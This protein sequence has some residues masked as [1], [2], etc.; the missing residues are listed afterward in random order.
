MEEE[1]ARPLGECLR[2][3]W[4]VESGRSRLR[5]TCLHHLRLCTCGE[6]PTTFL[7]H[8]SVS[9]QLQQSS[10]A[11]FRG[12]VGEVSF[13]TEDAVSLVTTAV[14]SAL[15]SLREAQTKFLLYSPF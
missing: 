9:S 7:T 10:D 4:V 13:L 2:G 6:P 1:A 11:C 15:G 3:V 5:A 12:Y 8:F 14:Q